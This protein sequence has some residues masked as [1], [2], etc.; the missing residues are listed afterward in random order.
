MKSEKRNRSL[1]KSRMVL[2]LIIA[3]T[4]GMVCPFPTVA[5]SMQNDLS[6]S[7]YQDFWTE[8]AE[9]KIDLGGTADT[10]FS[11]AYEAYLNVVIKC[12]EQY[13]TTDLKESPFYGGQMFTG[14]SFLSLVDFD[15]NGTEELLLVFYVND[16]GYVFNVWGFDGQKAVLLADGSGL[17]NTNGGMANVYLVRNAFGTYVVRGN[18]DSFEYNYYFGYAGQEFGL[19][20]YLGTE[21]GYESY[22]PD[23][24]EI[25]GI[26]VSGEEWNA[27]LAE[28]GDPLDSTERYCLT[29]Y[30]ESE[31][32][33]TMAIT[34]ETIQKLQQG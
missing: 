27:A 1:L 33:R 9:Y 5:E 16:Y 29:P 28:W 14:L 21:S 7:P 2:L 24:G 11:N 4:A 31:K 8:P 12:T 32:S 20:K 17:Y 3:L 6:L 18:A 23:G 19:V 10:V 34:N 15:G 30:N 13:G 26:P 25:D 22:S